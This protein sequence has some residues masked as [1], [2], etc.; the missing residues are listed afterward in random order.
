MQRRLNAVRTKTEIVNI[1]QV[2]WRKRIVV[3][4]EADRIAICRRHKSP[5]R[6]KQFANAGKRIEA[7]PLASA[8]AGQRLDRAKP[9]LDPRPRWKQA[10]GI[11]TDLALLVGIDGI[12]GADFPICGVRQVRSPVRHG[13]QTGQG[14]RFARAVVADPTVGDELAIEDDRQRIGQNF[15]NDR[16]VTWHH[17]DRQRFGLG[18]SHRLTVGP[19]Q[20]DFLAADNGNFFSVAQDKIFVGRIDDLFVKIAHVGAIVCKRPGRLAVVADVNHRRA[21]NGNAIGINRGLV[22]DQMRFM[23]RR[24]NV[25]AAMRITA[26]KRKAA[27]CFFGGN[28]PIV[29]G[30]RPNAIPPTVGR[31][32]KS[33]QGATDVCGGLWRQ[34]LVRSPLRLCA[35]C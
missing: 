30:I 14:L 9:C 22:Y 20:E 26:Q 1:T 35:R 13:Q 23:E 24:W 32:H 6:L 33:G 2:D 3:R 18:G 27:L 34:F 17:L 11:V 8:V 29:A 5:G 4:R 28:G 21:G 10:R 19:N 16:T 12:L 7:L 15:G 31:R 25:N